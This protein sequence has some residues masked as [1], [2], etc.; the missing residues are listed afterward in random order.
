MRG[1]AMKKIALNFALLSTVLSLS[2]YAQ[3]QPGQSATGTRSTSDGS[4]TNTSASTAPTTGTSSTAASGL[5]FTNKQG[6]SFSVDQLANELKTLRSTIDQTMPMLQAFNESYSNNVASD[7][8]LT[9]KISGLLSGALKRNESATNNNN[10][11]TQNSG[12]YS[13]VVG[14]L[15]GLLS[16]NNPN[17]STPISANTIRDLETLYGQLQPVSGTL[18]NLNVNIGSGSGSSTG[19][20]NSSSGL[21]PTGKSTGQR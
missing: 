7:G 11:S 1:I 16:K 5:A 13:D 15:Q 21:T 2:A 18:Q 8:T 19:T 14:A 3:N 12:R 20:T 10:G 6:Q 4:T 9:G 17:S